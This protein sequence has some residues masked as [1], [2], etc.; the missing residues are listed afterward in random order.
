MGA[1]GAAT[2]C[3]MLPF[4]SRADLPK[5][6]KRDVTYTTKV[7]VVAL[8]MFENATLWEAVVKQ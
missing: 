1:H 3:V 5:I 6:Q 4:W 7:S 8:A 2:L